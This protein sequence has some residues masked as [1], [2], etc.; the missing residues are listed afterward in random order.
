M[1][2]LLLLSFTAHTLASDDCQLNGEL[3][4]GTCRCDVGWKGSSCGDLDLNTEAI[5]AYGSGSE[6]DP[7]TSSWGGGPPA[8]DPITG[9]YHLFVSELA[10]N[11]GMNT[12]NRGSQAAHAVSKSPLGPFKRVDLA[13]GTET[14]NTYYA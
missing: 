2:T 4:G 9:Q 14:H 13:I 6:S 11:C 5:V 7:L 8:Y 3:T 12:W 10:A 1:W